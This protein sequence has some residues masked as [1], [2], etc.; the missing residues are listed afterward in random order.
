MDEESFTVLGGEAEAIGDRLEAAFEPG[1]DLAAAITRGA[2]AL[3]GPDRVLGAGD[4]EVAVLE[5]NGGR[6]AF[7]RIDHDHLEGFLPRSTEPATASGTPTADTPPP[8]ADDG[9]AAGTEPDAS[10]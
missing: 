9:G 1:L 8:P 5:R 6:R 7:R 10:G 2:A 3:G 4:L